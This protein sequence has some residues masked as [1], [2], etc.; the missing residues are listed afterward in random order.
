M[1]TEIRRNSEVAR[2]LAI[3]AVKKLCRFEC[4][5]TRT[6]RSNTD[7]HIVNIHLK[8]ACIDTCADETRNQT[9]QHTPAGLDEVVFLLMVCLIHVLGAGQTNGFHVGKQHPVKE[10]TIV[11]VDKQPYPITY[12][13]RRPEIIR[14]G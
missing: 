1:L 7:Y 5:E 10:E 14:T 8:D 13:Q 3:F 6:V 9:Y 4:E 11:P 2:R 12:T